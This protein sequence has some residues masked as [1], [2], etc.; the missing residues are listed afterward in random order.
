MSKQTILVTGAAGF[1][2]FHVAKKL[3]EDGHTIIGIDNINDYYDQRLKL[4]R[5]KILSEF[6]NYFFYKIDIIKREELE[7]VF[8]KHSINKTCHLAAQAG[9]RYSLENPFIYEEVNIRGFLNVIEASKKSGVND[10]VYASSSSIYGNSKMPKTGFTEKDT[11][12]D[13][14]SFYGT[15]K[16]SNELTAAT[17]HHLYKMNFTG[18]RFFTAYGPW[19]RPDMAYFSFTK[20]ILEDVPL[21][22]F[23]FGKM[24]RDFTY[25]DDVVDGVITA[26]STS[27]SNEIFNIGNSHTIEL[28]YFIS[29]LEQALG[30][31]AVLD[32][33]PHQSG[34]V[35]ETF[36]DIS[37][38]R[39][40]LT[41]KPLI[42]IEEGVRRFVGWY[43]EYYKI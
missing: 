13:Q 34:D 8:S 28:K 12:G 16:R 24:K 3:L 18:L 10:I 43:K 7:K 37:H 31:K 20:A 32:F 21:K 17:Y 42:E 40:Q 22:V 2:G 6:E 9:V 14:V 36:A 26:L 38:A 35:Y 5:N 29:C 11:L 23:N 19:G 1:I 27:F 4:D 30:K 33:V 41:F 39:K 15:T 25:I